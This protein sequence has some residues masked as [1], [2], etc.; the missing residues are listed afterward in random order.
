M[1]TLW[2]SQIDTR[3]DT[4][5]AVALLLRETFDSAEAMSF[6]T[7]RTEYNGALAP[8]NRHDADVACD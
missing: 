4:Y 5:E 1:Q 2:P 7:I 6:P 8:F 3:Q